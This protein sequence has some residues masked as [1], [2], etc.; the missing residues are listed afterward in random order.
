MYNTSIQKYFLAIL[1][2]VVWTLLCL[3]LES[4]ILLVFNLFLIDVFI[5]K[6]V[7]WGF[8]NR[9]SLPPW[10]SIFWE[11]LKAIVIALFITLI[12]RTFF[13]EAYKIPTPSMERTLLVGDYLLVSKLAYGPRLPFT[14]FSFPF[15]PSL[16]PDGR[17]TYRETPQIPYKRLKGFSKVKRN[18]VIVFNFPEGD[19]VATEFQGQNYYSLLRQYGRQYVES[20]LKLIRHPIDK[21]DHYIKRCIAIPGDTILIK[22][23]EVYLNNAVVDNYEKQLFK[24]YVRTRKERLNDSILNLLGVKEEELS[25]HSSDNVHIIP[26]DETGCSVLKNYAEVQS[27]QKYTEP[28]HSYRNTEIFP[29]SLN[30]QWSAD[31]FGPLWVPG[32]GLTVELNTENLPLYHRIIS[33]YEENKIEINGEDIYINGNLANSYTFLMNYYFVLGDNRSNS[34]DSRYWGLVPEDHLVGKAKHIWF[35]KTPDMGFMKGIKTERMFK[36]IK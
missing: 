17:V 1:S 27:M 11:W 26:L 16:L 13:V 34:A 20:N 15:L 19:T 36:T 29:H 2:I 23:S 4:N 32:K 9:I 31:E 3:W 12:I 7:K 22:R 35:S 28:V 24:F 25:Y 33:V 10:L 21:R 14:P 30:Y 8:L 6:W 18:D 5:T